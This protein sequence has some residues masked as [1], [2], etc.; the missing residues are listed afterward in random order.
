MVN[1]RLTGK[2]EMRSG[3]QLIEEVPAG[4]VFDLDDPYVG[5]EADL[6]C[7]IGFDIRIRRG[8]LAQTGAEGT[9]RRMRLLEHRLRRRRINFS[10]AVK[11]IDLDED[12]AGFFRA[13]PAHDGGS[14]F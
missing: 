13:A 7:Q 1:G 10:R 6:L 12:R 4:A 2:A 8:L 9:V 3:A 5:I 14:T 11:P